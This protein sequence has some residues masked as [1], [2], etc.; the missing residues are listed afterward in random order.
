[1]TKNIHSNTGNDLASF[2]EKKVMEVKRIEREKDL[3]LTNYYK[4]MM[5]RKDVCFSQ[6]TVCRMASELMARKGYSSPLSG[7]GVRK[8]LVKLGVI[9]KE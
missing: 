7:E 8:R 9:K 3:L 4:G 6:T 1:M 5:G 2:Y